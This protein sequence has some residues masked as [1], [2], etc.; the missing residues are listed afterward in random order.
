MLAYQPTDSLQGFSAI[1]IGELTLGISSPSSEYP[2]RV[3]VIGNGRDGTEKG[4]A[5]SFDSWAVDPEIQPEPEADEMQ[6]WYAIQT[7]P[8]HEKRVD[9]D[10]RAKGFST[11]L[12]TV[13]QT[14]Q[15]TDRKK[16]VQVP[17]F[18]RYLFIRSLYRPEI[19][20]SVISLPGVSGFVGIRGRALPIPDSEIA[21]VQLLLAHKVP[22][23]PYPFIRVGQRVRCRGGALEGLEGIL[24]SKNRDYSVVISLE[25]LQRSLAVRVDGYH[26]EPVVEPIPSQATRYVPPQ[27]LGEN[28]FRASRPA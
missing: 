12:P 22:F 9:Q 19:H 26:L 18:A 5:M 24:V 1:W 3:R 27:S 17:L 7:R 4:E 20:H 6:N 23:E 21:N 28:P 14:H 8:R 10:L 15:W 13:E 16:K 2:L 11:F 25:L